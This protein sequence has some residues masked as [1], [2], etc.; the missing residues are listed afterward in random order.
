MFNLLKQ[1]LQRRPLDLHVSPLIT[2][3]LLKVKYFLPE[4]L[5]DKL[6]SCFQHD[7]L[8]LLVAHVS[9]VVGDVECFHGD[10]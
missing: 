4:L 2:L 9:E 1:H 8:E 6:Q 5:H 10:L 3:R 7:K